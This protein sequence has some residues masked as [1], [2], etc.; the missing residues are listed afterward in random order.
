MWIRQQCPRNADEVELT[1]ADETICLSDISD[2]PTC[3]HRQT[4]LGT[5][6]LGIR[7]HEI[8]PPRYRLA[9]G[10]EGQRA[11]NKVHA[12]FFQPL[13]NLDGLRH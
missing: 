8:R 12:S 9:S 5:N 10:S 1:I 6:A 13:Q 2:H 11:V 3:P 4:G 7:H